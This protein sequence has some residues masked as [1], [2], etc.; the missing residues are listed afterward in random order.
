M[1]SVKTMF[2]LNENN[3]IFHSLT[4]W[5]DGVVGGLFDESEIKT[6]KWMLL[7]WFFFI[8]FNFNIL[9][10]IWYDQEIERSVSFDL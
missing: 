1:K 3:Q 6:T 4:G 2:I 7:G 10:N 9:Q 8:H 5:V